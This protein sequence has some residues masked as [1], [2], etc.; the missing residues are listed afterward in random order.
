MLMII[1][2]AHFSKRESGQKLW[3]ISRDTLTF[4]LFPDGKRLQSIDSYCPCFN[5]HRERELSFPTLPSVYYDIHFIADFNVINGIGRIDDSDLR[6]QYHISD[7][8]RLLRIIFEEKTD[9]HFLLAPNVAVGICADNVLSELL[10][11]GLMKCGDRR[12]VK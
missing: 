10:F 4:S 2:F 12:I 9:S 5:W 11:D 6:I 8:D 3:R 1:F 7:N